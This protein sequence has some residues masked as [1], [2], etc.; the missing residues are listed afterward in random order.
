M[1][2][3]HEEL[4]GAR[5][6]LH[7]LRVVVLEVGVLVEPVQVIDV[8]AGLDGLPERKGEHG[9]GRRGHG[10][11]PGR[12]IA[13]GPCV[14]LHPYGAGL[15]DAEGDGDGDGVGVAFGDGANDWA[16]AGAASTPAAT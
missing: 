2:Q 13:H 10:H 11:E 4:A 14:L 12:A 3:R 7:G 15:D 9:Q 1:P 16:G 5:Q 8:A 6:R